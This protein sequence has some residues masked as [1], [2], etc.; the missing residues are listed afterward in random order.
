MKTKVAI[1]L[2]AVLLLC[3]C[4]NQPKALC[5]HSGLEPLNPT[6]HNG[7]EFLYQITYDDYNFELAEQLTEQRLGIT[8]ARPAGCSSIRIGNLVGRNLDY[9]VDSLA[10]VVVYM[11]AGENR[12][13]SVGMGTCMPFL[14]KS[15]VD[16]Q[17]MSDTL[18]NKIPYSM[19]DGINEKG[20]MVNV[21]VVP[22]GECEHT[23]GTNPGAPVLAAAGVTRYLLDH[24]TSVDHAISLL[25][26]RN[27]VAASPEKFPF[28]THWMISDSSKT[29]VVEIWNNQLVVTPNNAMTN[30]YVSHPETLY[31]QGIERY[32]LLQS[33]KEMAIDAEGMFNLMKKVWYSQAYST[34]TEPV[35][36]S[37]YFDRNTGL[38]TE[39]VK[40]GLYSKFDS[41]RVAAEQRYQNINYQKSLRLGKDWYTTHT[42]I[43][44]LRER[45]FML[46]AQ[47]NESS[48]QI[49]LR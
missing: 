11:K 38:S 28:E 27:L 37:E 16:S 47:E 13:A 43:Y 25:Q 10:D 35:W 6:A 42:T 22:L 4:S 18:Y 23:S 24:A 19:T 7:D 2:S 26:E 45:S 15:L 12:L 40:A 41:I 34:Q 46:V 1:C 20:L 39:V 9:Y 36:Y 30:F 17:S 8:P 5:S 33:N 49:S 21:N 29:V 14:T 44:N 31:G 32:A 3:A 48:Y